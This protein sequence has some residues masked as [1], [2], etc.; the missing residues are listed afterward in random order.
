MSGDLTIS[1]ARC[2]VG[3]C[4]STAHH[5][6]LKRTGETFYCVNGHGNVYNHGKSEADRLREEL[7]TVRRERDRAWQTITERGRRIEELKLTVRG[8][9]GAIGRMRKQREREEAHDGET[10]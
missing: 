1:C 8:L 5:A 9:K 2:G 10:A 7:E 4:L 3:I 6:Q